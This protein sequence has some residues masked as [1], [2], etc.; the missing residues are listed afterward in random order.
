MNVAYEKLDNVRGKLTVTIEENDY[1]DKVKAQ[2]KEIR[3]SQAVPGFRPGKAPASMI[4]KKYGDA[5]KY[6]VVNKEIGNALFGYIRENKLH[7]LGNPVPAETNN[8]DLQNKDFTLEFTVGLAPEIDTHVNK[9]LHVPFYTIEVSDKMVDDQDTNMRRRLGKQEPGEVADDT[10]VI[11]GVITELDENGEPKVEGIVVENGIISPN[12]FRSEDQK[13]LFANCKVGDVVRFNPAAT[14]NANPT[15][16]SSM[17]NIDKADVDSHKGDF[18]FEVK[19]IIVLKPAELGE[20]YYKQVFGPET[21]IKTE[22][23]Y[24]QALRNMIATALV[25]D[26]NYRFTI[27]AREAIQKAVGNLEL[28]DEIL[29]EFLRT[30]N[31]S[32]NDENIEAEYEAA[33]PHLQWELIRDAIGEQ[34][35]VNV[36]NEDVLNTARMMARQQFAQYGM[37]NVGDEIVDKYANDILKDKKAAENIYGQTR[38]MKLYAAIKEAVT[39]DDKNVTVEEFN[40]LFTPAELGADAAEEAKEMDHE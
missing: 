13:K 29:K 18:N 37:A 6:D 1:A 35:D 12:Y 36:T 22:E 34:L 28:P 8:F 23:E 21:E 10:A 2:L 5:V 3:K 17:L 30:Q 16:M 31:E 26:S 14:C 4:E 33:R 39:C 38:D 15:E 32:L 24:R 25:S 11:K 27:D 9:D 40:A 7:V 20:E 19:E